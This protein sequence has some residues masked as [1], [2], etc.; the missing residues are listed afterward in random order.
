MFVFC[1]VLLFVVA[2][3]MNNRESAAKIGKAPEFCPA[4]GDEAVTQALKPIRQKFNVPAMV[5]A[6][7]TSDGIKLVGAVGVRKRGAEIPVGLD[8]LWHLGSDGKAMTSTLI[9]RLVEQNKLKWDSP[10]AEIF[11]DLAPQMNPEFQKVTLP[12][13]L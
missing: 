11:P 7:V 9:A 13:L 10:L 3:I 12:Q 1:V 8:D 2:W 5:A 6:V 4:A